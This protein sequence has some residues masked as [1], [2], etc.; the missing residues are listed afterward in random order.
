MK[1]F[2]KTKSSLNRVSDGTSPEE[3]FSEIAS[4]LARGYARLQ[5]QIGRLA[6]AEAQVNSLCAGE[7]NPPRHD[8]NYLDKIGLQR[9]HGR[10]RLTEAIT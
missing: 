5:R 6:P 2:P 10:N 7:I 3:R 9:S 8:L 4:I 1:P